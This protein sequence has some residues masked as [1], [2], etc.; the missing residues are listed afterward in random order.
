MNRTLRSIAVLLALAAA[1]AVAGWWMGSRKRPPPG[2]SMAGYTER[3]GE[4]LAEQVLKSGKPEGCVLVIKPDVQGMANPFDE[5][6]V[7]GITR[8]LKTSDPALEVIAEPIQTDPLTMAAGRGAFAAAEFLRLLTAHPQCGVVIS[9][10][11]PPPYTSELAEAVKR[12]N[13]RLVVLALFGEAI[14]D[15]ESAGILEAA[16][17]ARDPYEAPAST[18][19]PATLDARFEREFRVVPEAGPQD[20]PGE[21]FTPVGP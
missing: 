21:R 1:V 9:T 10:A 7:A 17:I 2:Q 4:R 8:V 11:G 15:L 5:A 3:I 6:Y 13:R 20:G 12:G 18:E 19:P 16:V 14:A